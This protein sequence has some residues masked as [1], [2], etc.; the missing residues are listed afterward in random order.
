MSKLS[1]SF[2]TKTLKRP[3]VAC[4]IV[5]FAIREGALQLLLIKRALPPYAGTWALPGG[6]VLPEETLDHAAKRELR[7]ESGVRVSG[8]YLEQLY[9]FGDVHRDPRGRVISVTYLAVVQ[10]EGI[11]PHGGSDAADAQW[12]EVA[13]LPRLAF[14]HAAIIAY[15]LER[16]RYKLEYT[17]IMYAALPP[18]FTLPELQTAYEAVLGRPLDR[19]NFRKKLADLHFV[20]PTQEWRKPERGRP[21]QLWRFASRAPV[22]VK[23][24]VTKA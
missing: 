12:W 24:F 7:E 22:S 6:F 9:T 18:R 5:V 21:A 2:A 8:E 4:D 15:A 10:G 14:D 1:P 20:R 13:H 16:L 17:N 19:R 11:A 23:S 3:L